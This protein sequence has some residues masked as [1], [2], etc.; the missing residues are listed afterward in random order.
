MI[1][2]SSKENLFPGVSDQVIL[3]YL[4]AQLQTLA[5]IMT[6]HMWQDL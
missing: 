2:V 4:S 6:F 5:R 1:W 3:I